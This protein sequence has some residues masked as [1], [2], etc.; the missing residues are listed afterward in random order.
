M[1]QE[2][3]RST[4]VV[5]TGHRGMIGQEVVRTLEAGG[6]E[7]RGLD[8]A[9]GQ[10]VRDSGTVREAVSGAHFV[11]HLAALDD[12]VD[13]PGAI[14]PRST[15]GPA[16]VT[17]TNVRGTAVLLREAE[18]SRIDRFVLLSSI[19]VL[20]CFT[21]QGLPAYLPL[22]DDH[23]VDPRGA[24]AHS[25]LAAEEL[26][27]AF[28][29]TTGTPTLC[30]RPPGVVDADIAAHIRAVRNEHPESEYL[31]FWEYG[32]FI[33][34]R[35]L[36]TCIYRALVAPRVRGHHRFLVNGPDISSSRFTTREL[37]GMVV[38]DVPLLAEAVREGGSYAPL[39]DTGPVQHLLDWSPRH[40][41]H[42]QPEH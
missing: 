3:E 19:D 39:L 33:D 24:Y 9:D 30:L 6:M 11:V 40:Y 29:A 7:V 13:N 25:K 28:T 32:A 15:G 35:D 23:P 20:G 17:E 1:R 42:R 21:G 8:L 38:P 26:C 2:P 4:T 16:A 27:A 10:D 36:A 41:W 31:P 18:R 5:V 22:D 14:D 12:A 34:V 37:L